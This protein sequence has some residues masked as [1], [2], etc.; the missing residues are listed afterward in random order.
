MDCDKF[1]QQ[2]FS[3]KSGGKWQVMKKIFNQII[4]YIWTKNLKPAY[5]VITSNFYPPPPVISCNSF[6]I[7]VLIIVLLILII[8]I[9]NV[10]LLYK[11]CSTE[12]YIRMIVNVNWK[13]GRGK[14]S[15]YYYFFSF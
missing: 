14:A 12:W 8:N 11:L 10:V 2:L 5:I 3:I 15:S 7:V 9:I 4:K 6:N 1:L 13:H